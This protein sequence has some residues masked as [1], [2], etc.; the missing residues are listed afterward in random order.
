M[1]FKSQSFETCYIM[2]LL[3]R[4]IDKH[5]DFLSGIFKSIG[6]FVL[7]L[8][9]ITWSFKEVCNECRIPASEGFD[10]RHWPGRSHAV[11][12]K[13]ASLWPSCTTSEFFLGG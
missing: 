7:P 13:D 3:S 4:R 12:L 6:I 10:G 9:V 2:K 5:L 8:K 1:F 11:R